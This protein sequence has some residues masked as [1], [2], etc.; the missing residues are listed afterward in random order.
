MPRSPDA[1]IRQAT[2][3]DLARVQEIVR[4]AY[5]PYIARIGKPPGPMQDDYAALIAE[6]HVWV[7][8]TPPAGLLVLIPQD[9]HVLL[10]NVAVAPE[11]HG[12]GIGRALLQFAEQY[13]TSCGLPELRLY[14]HELMTEN[15]TMYAST[16]WTETGRGNQNG[17][18][19]VFFRK[20]ITG[21]NR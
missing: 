17:F 1:A 5:T 8:G 14:T 19:R 2:P 6:G 3:H 18:A 16:G 10:D 13:A 15:L 20:T 12:K 11:S 7:I 21:T 4:A 9:E